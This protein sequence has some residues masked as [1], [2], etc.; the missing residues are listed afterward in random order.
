MQV[1]LTR[2]DLIHFKR[3][4]IDEALGYMLSQTALLSPDISEGSLSYRIQKELQRY[5]DRQKHTGFWRR[6]WDSLGWQLRYYRNHW[7]LMSC[8]WG[9]TYSSMIY[10]PIW[11]GTTPSDWIAQ[12]ILIP[13]LDGIYLHTI[14]PLLLAIQPMMPEVIEQWYSL[15][16]Y[17]FGGIYQHFHGGVL[18]LYHGLHQAIQHQSTIPPRVASSSLV[19]LAVAYIGRKI[20]PTAWIRRLV[21][22]VEDQLQIGHRYNVAWR[23]VLTATRVTAQISVVVLQEQELAL[24]SA[25]G[26]ESFFQQVL[27]EE[28]PPCLHARPSNSGWQLTLQE[29]EQLKRMVQ[30]MPIPTP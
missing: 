6:L 24:L 8:L 29:T 27:Q 10:F 15:L 11:F 20:H 1:R 13:V 17:W 30:A 19:V 23:S 5:C 25:F 22:W 2:S 4:H 9:L 28:P 26:E 14:A 3:N 21:M 7:L 18:Y 12:H 16:V